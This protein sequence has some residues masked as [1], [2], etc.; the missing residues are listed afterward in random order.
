M[1]CN[2]NRNSTT[3]TANNVGAI[4]TTSSSSTSSSAEGLAVVRVLAAVL[5][6]LVS[7]NSG[8]AAVDPGPVTKFHALKAPS[9]SVLHYLERIHKYASCSTECFV[10]AL[11]YID[12]MIQ[13]N[14]FL[15][16]ELNV[17]RVVITG[18]LLAAKFFDDAYYNN[19]YYAKVGGVLV[20]EM[21]SLEVEFLFRINFS[22]HVT[23]DVYSKYHAELLLHA[24][25]V[26]PSSANSL[27]TNVC[28]RPENSL[29]SEEDQPWNPLSTQQTLPMQPQIPLTS[30]DTNNTTSVQITPSP[31][32]VK[33]TVSRRQTWT[34]HP[35]I[36]V[37]GM[38]VNQY[39]NVAC[40]PIVTYPHAVVY[41]RHPVIYNS[42]ST[43]PSN[44][45]FDPCT[46]DQPPQ[47]SYF[48]DPADHLDNYCVNNDNKML[49]HNHLN[50]HHLNTANT[51]RN[52]VNPA[53]INLV[54]N[55]TTTT[56]HNHHVVVNTR[57][58]S[59]HAS[60][61]SRHSPPCIVTSSKTTSY[62]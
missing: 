17:H 61:L 53:L 31:P 24:V 54:I 57:R 16:T 20:A 25:T 4:T 56:H 15:L 38:A 21:N 10:L 5:E 45:Y 60:T 50:N 44:A 52:V 6:R 30:V 36:D 12:R 26:A 9:I 7:T 62:N 35:D 43:T 46:T 23:P 49:M 18:V 22:L 33:G 8:L 59:D 58:H 48:P 47:S 2:K 14:N 39:P 11:I 29:V 42:T 55:N 13:R 51:Y 3:S 41:Q 27:N 32:S 28:P 37:V 34:P 40:E 19:A 1:E